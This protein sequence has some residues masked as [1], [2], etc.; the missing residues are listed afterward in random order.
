MFGPP[1]LEELRYFVRGFDQDK[2]RLIPNS[3]PEVADTPPPKEKRLLWLGRVAHEQKRAELIVPIWQRIHR[4][5]PGWH[6][7]V[8]GDGPALDDLRRMA[9]DLN[10]PRIH[11]HGRQLPEDFYRRSPIFFM[12][13]AFEG[14]PNT[15]VEAQSHAAI[16][17]IF[18]SYPVASWIVK[19]GRSGRLVKPFDTEAMARCILE[20]TH[21]RC[22]L[23]M[24]NHV[25]ESA[26]RFHIDRVG[27]MWQELFD[28]EVPKHVQRRETEP[29]A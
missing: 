2:V 11:F 20:L 9:G 22:R 14:F 21:E 8:V 5:M 19:D 24:V 17:V 4:E 16:P 13:S 12:T 10:L 15:L 26:R 25:L 28:S 18:D 7:D 6:L 23:T 29:V 1:N 3:I 27:D